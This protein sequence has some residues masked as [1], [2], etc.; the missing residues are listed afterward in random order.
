MDGGDP[1]LDGVMMDDE[2]IV[3]AFAQR[4]A[5]D[6]RYVDLLRSMLPLDMSEAVPALQPREAPV[7]IQRSAA[8]GR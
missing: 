3:A 2:P 6:D 8:P 5:L 7:M 1:L 4:R